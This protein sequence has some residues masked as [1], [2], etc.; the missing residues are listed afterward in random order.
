MM[1][2]LL[3]L[4]MALRDPTEPMRADNIKL[5]EILRADNVYMAIID[6]EIYKEGDAVGLYKIV[7]IDG[8]TVLLINTVTQTQRTLSLS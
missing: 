8:K 7:R 5:T 6:D 4:N 2:L 1:A 3:V